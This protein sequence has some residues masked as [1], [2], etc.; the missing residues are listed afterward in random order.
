MQTKICTTH[1]PVTHVEK[2][3]FWQLV[4]IHRYFLQKRNCGQN[5]SHMWRESLIYDGKHLL[6]LYYQYCFPQRNVSL[7]YCKCLSL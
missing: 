2:H 6:L 7:I 1:Y 3:I 5:H 4:D